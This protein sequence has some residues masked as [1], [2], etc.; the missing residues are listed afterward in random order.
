LDTFKLLART[1]THTPCWAKRLSHAETVCLLMH[2]D[3]SLL[4]VLLLL[5]LQ[6]LQV[7]AAAA[8]QVWPRTT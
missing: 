3:P 7:H 1:G 6:T 8:A 5:L 2:S 4:L